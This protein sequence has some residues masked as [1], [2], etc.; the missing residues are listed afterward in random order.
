[1]HGGSTHRHS[2]RE[3]R[4]QSVHCESMYIK[5]KTSKARS[6]DSDGAQL[7]QSCPTLCDPMDHSPPASSVHS[8]LQARVPEWVTMP[9]STR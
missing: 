7:L 9:F 2:G 1:M 3:T 6:Q 5:F 8:V 4:P